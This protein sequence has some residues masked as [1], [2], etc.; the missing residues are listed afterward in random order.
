MPEDV[1]AVQKLK[2]Q[3]FPTFDG[4]DDGT[5]FLIWEDQVEKMMPKV[6]D[7]NEKKNYL[8][9]CLIDGAKEF[10]SSVITKEMTYEVLMGKLKGRYNDPLVMNSK[11]L[12]QLF[13]GEEFND[14]KSTLNT[15]IRLLEE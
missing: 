8:L 12:H 9:G 10:I 15:G 3:E 4:T 2:A 14:P 11:L 1:I 13:F 7:P 6:K 5:T